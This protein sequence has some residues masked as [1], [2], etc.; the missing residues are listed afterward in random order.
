MEALSFL[1]RRGYLGHDAYNVGPS[2]LRHPFALVRIHDRFPPTLDVDF[3][4]LLT[5]VVCSHLSW[6]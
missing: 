1:Y 3:F 5:I 2:P 4:S 6:S